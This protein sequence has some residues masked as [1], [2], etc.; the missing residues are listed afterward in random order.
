MKQEIASITLVRTGNQLRHFVSGS[1]L[2]I[3]QVA[4]NYLD[5]IENKLKAEG[6]RPTP[7]QDDGWRP[8]SEQM[9][10]DI[11]VLFKW[12]TVDG[13]EP[14][15]AIGDTYKGEGGSTL[16]RHH[17]NIQASP[18]YWKPIN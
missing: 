7:D 9:P 12:D 5:I 14:I 17:E 4:H 16:W 13:D 1:D 8:M 11:Q 10:A 3:T 6:L 2:E 18:N 15:L